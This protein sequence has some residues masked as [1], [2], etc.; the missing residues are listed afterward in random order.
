M[1]PVL[2]LTSLTQVDVGGFVGGNSVGG[3]SVGITVVFDMT[4]FCRVS[5]V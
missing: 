1:N 2:A 5:N 3:N 4:S